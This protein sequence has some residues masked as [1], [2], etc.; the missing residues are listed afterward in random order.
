MWYLGGGYGGI[1]PIRHARRCGIRVVEKP[2]VLRYTSAA[3]RDGH[4]IHPKERMEGV[5]QEAM[6]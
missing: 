3:Q 5:V 6:V 4:D 2:W 1:D